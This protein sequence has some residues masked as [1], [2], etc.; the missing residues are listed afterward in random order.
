MEHP[1]QDL[2][3]DVLVVFDCPNCK[4]R[5]TFLGCSKV[6]VYP[7]GQCGQQVDIKALSAHERG[8]YPPKP[9]IEEVG[10]TVFSHDCPL[11]GHHNVFVGWTELFGYICAGCGHGVTVEAMEQ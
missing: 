1:P 8:V 4:L 11:C 5:N 2:G 6:F 3:D 9:P 10:D 7:C